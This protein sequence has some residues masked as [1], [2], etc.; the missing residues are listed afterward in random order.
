LLS[1]GVDTTIDSLGLC[2]RALAEQ[3]D[4]WA[5]LRG[6]PQLARSAFE[7]ATR[8]DSSSQSLFRTTLED[9]DFQGV[10]LLKHQK[11]LVLIGAAGRDPAKWAEPDRFDITRR[12]TAS[13][14][15]YGAGIHSCVA[16]MMARLEAE[17]FFSVL[18]RKVLTIEVIGP[19]ELRL[20]PGLR[21][22]KSLPLRLTRKA[23]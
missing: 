23:N 21:G 13:Q 12:V 15:G 6:N 9:I 14:I 11:V 16:Q 1:A 20:Q 22:L 17:V 2:L 18:A 3:P 4:Q 19:S 10:K 5:L 7:E 8:Y